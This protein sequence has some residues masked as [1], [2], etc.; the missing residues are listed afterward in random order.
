MPP[1]ATAPSASPSSS[2]TA[3][4]SGCIDTWL[5]ANQTCPLCR[6]TFH[7]TEADVLNK[8]VLESEASQ[9]R[10]P[11]ESGWRSYSLGSFDYIVDEG[12]YGKGLRRST[13]FSAQTAGINPSCGSRRRTELAEGLCRQNFGH[14][15][16]LSCDVVSDLRQVLHW[17]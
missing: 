11:S 8:L 13:D 10:A 5:T 3:F 15:F 12:L 14:F 17:E 16:F 9:R 4:H 2:Q 7:P 6:S 1:A